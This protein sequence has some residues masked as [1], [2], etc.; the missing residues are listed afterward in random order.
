MLK[1]GILCTLQKTMSQESLK[2]ELEQR[3]FLYQYS[4][5]KVFAL[6]EKGGQTLYIGVD[7]TA[8]SIHLGT[9]A[10]LM[11][12]VTYMKRGNKLILIVGGATGMVGDP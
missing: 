10:A 6:Y 2:S 8:D 9:M 4:D 1:D 3:G 11:H 12:A 7:P 5:E